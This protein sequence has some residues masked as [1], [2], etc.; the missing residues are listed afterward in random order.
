MDTDSFIIEV[1]NQNIILGNKDQFDTSNFCKDS[2]LYNNENKNKPGTMKDEYAENRIRLKPKSYSIIAKNNKENCLH[3][4]H[5]VNFTGDEYKDVLHNNK[6]LTHQMDQI[7]SMDHVLFTKKI[8]K[9]SLSS[10]YNKGYYLS[11]EDRYL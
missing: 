11:S 1:I 7:V 10:F 5:T 2:E 6:I 4:E 9:Q 8:N 3:K